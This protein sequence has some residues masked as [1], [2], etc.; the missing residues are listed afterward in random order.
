MILHEEFRY[1]LAGDT[2]LER[3]PL[4]GNEKQRETYII[5]KAD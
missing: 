2:L 5:S 3:K 1:G 4:R